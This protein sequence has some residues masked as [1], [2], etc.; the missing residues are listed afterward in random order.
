MIMAWLLLFLFIFGIFIGGYAMGYHKGYMRGITDE[1]AR[2]HILVA[3]A[4]MPRAVH[5]VDAYGEG[6]VAYDDTT[7]GR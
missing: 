2:W 4:D 5:T 3:H 1:Q 6:A 7:A